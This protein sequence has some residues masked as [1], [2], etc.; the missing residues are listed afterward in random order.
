M[1]EAEKKLAEAERKIAESE[2][3]RARESVAFVQSGS[4]FD[5]FIPDF[6]LHV[7][8]GDDKDSKWFLDSA[9][10]NHMTGELGDIIDFKEF[11]TD[12]PR[13][14]TLA[15]KSLVPALGEGHMNMY[16]CDE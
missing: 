11:P 3:K 15:D 9:C 6:A 1:A 10:S 14:V 2:E 16:L 7:S 5:G 8:D 12:E 4:N 13:Y